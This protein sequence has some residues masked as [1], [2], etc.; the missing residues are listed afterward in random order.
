MNN[1][2]EQQKLI[3]ILRGIPQNKVERVAQA[4]Y[5]GGARVMEVTFDQRDPNTLTDTAKKIKAINGLL[6]S[7]ALVGAGTVLT[8]EQV[9]AAFD[10]GAKFILSPNTD[11]EIIKYTKQLGMI[12][13][14][15]AFTPTEIMTAYN[16]GADYVK[17]FPVTRDDVGYL[18]NITAP[19]SHLPLICTGG[20]NPD[21]IQLFLQNGATA[22]GTGASILKKELVENDDYAEITRLTQLHFEKINEL[23]A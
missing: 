3:V 5:D 23:K 21:T 1:L 7:N 8:K 9:K 19:I 13:V 12:S 11:V 17:V 14:P 20:V 10:A 2:I 4:L 18:K 6:G 16:S 15:G 22:L